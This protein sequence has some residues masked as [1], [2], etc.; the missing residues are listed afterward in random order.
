MRCTGCHGPVAFERTV[1]HGTQPTTIRLCATCATSADVLTHL[2]AI[3][4]APDHPTKDAA[5]VNLLQAVESVCSEA[6]PSEG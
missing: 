1:F 6:A 3:K 4:A 2:K 5:V